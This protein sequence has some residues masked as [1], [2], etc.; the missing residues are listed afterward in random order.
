MKRVL[1]KILLYSLLVTFT[2]GFKCISPEPYGKIVFS[3]TYNP[4]D[5]T[6]DD[7]I[8][9]MDIDGSGLK[10]LTNNDLDE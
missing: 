9:I 8:Y 7:E 4:G 6:T 10:Q 3:S 5:S 2:S 1:I